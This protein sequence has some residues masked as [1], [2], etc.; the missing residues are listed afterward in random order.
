MG[1]KTRWAAII[2]LLLVL[3]LVSVCFGEGSVVGAE[4]RMFV[5]P[6]DYFS[7]FDAV[8]NASDGDV[9]FVK[10]GTYD[11]SANKTLLVD[12]TISLI[13][14]EAKSTIL[15]LHPKYVEPDSPFPW[16]NIPYYEKGVMMEAQNVLFSGFTIRST[17]LIF[18]AGQNNQI[19][20]N[21]F[22]AN[23]WLAN[24][25]IN[26]SHNTIKNGITCQAS[27]NIIARNKGDAVHIGVG[28][29]NYTI[30]D[31]LFVNG[32]GI[33]IAGD[34]NRIF[35]N[36]VKNCSVGV[37]MGASASGNLVYSNWLTNN[38]VGLR[39]RSEGDNNL[40]YDNHVENNS[41]GAQVAWRRPMGENNTLYHNNFID[42]TI[43][44][45]TEP[46]IQLVDG[47][48]WTAYHGGYFDNGKEGNYWSNYKGTDANG[49]GIGDTPYIIDENRQDKYP[50]MNPADITIIPEFPSWILLMML[51]QFQL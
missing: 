4:G 22:E 5:V 11:G 33:G 29:T 3:S 44:V 12:K 8:G 43:Q 20:D 18:V 46:F 41:Y 42:N 31:N 16:Y 9:I 39:V 28:V 27:S 7:V 10:K 35:N 24:S 38:T 13:G 15:N 49:D 37:G 1:Y 50:L 26:V 6:D 36:T 40:F 51:M 21:M 17:G 25:Q 19:I 45:N 48:N 2:V 47:S 23:L 14:E 34:L 30:H 32:N